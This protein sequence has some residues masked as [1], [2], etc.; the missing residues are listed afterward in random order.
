MRMPSGPAPGSESVAATVG[1]AGA[2]G[3]TGAAAAPAGAGASFWGPPQ[4][5]PTRL[6][7]PKSRRSCMRGRSHGSRQRGTRNTHLAPREVAFVAG[8]LDPRGR[9]AVR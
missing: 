8:Q 1:P 9:L 3:A 6:I 7:V 5:T 2:A 4:A